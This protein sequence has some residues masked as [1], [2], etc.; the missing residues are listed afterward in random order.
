M[1]HSWVAKVSEGK[2]QVLFF[3]SNEPATT[4]WKE[5]KKKREKRRD[6]ELTIQTIPP[7][8][9]ILHILSHDPRH[10]LQIIV[11]TSEVSCWT[12]QTCRGGGGVGRSRRGS[13][14]VARGKVRSR[15]GVFVEAR[16][17]GH[18]RIWDGR[19]TRDENVSV[20]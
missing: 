2:G 12:G 13:G 1:G 4:G 6:L 10:I 14:W 9:Q 17:F 16:G 7:P 20:R 3:L 5:S 18:E 15:S 19:W 8:K 11:D